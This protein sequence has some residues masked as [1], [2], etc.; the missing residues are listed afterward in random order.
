[1]FSEGQ[2]ITFYLGMILGRQQSIVSGD[3]KKIKSKH[4]QTKAHEQIQAKHLPAGY[5]FLFAIITV[6]NTHCFTCNWR[7]K[8]MPTMANQHL[9][10]IGWTLERC[11]DGSLF[12]QKG[13]VFGDKILLKIDCSSSPSPP[14]IPCYFDNNL[15]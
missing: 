6:Q 13:I 12:I 7:L 14:P 15:C 4:V 1:M 2:S 11:D 8:I 5:C 3:G 9:L 10:L